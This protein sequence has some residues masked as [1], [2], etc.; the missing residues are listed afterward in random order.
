MAK[1]KFRTASEIKVGTI[2]YGASF[3]I[4]RH[5]LRQMQQAGM[6]PVAVADIDPDRLPEAAA[7]FPGIAT[8]N[9]ATELLASCDVDLLAICTPHNSHAPLAIECMN[10]GRHVVT[11]KP[12]AVNTEECDAMIAAR[13]RNRVMLSTYH[14]RHWDSWIINA[15]EKISGGM[16]GDVIRAQIDLCGYRCPKDTWRSSKTISGGIMYDWGAHCLEYAL[17]ILSGR[18]T[19][20]SG[21]A[22]RGFWAPRTCWGDDCIEDDTLAV[23]RFDSGQW[24]TMLNSNVDS[25]PRPPYMV[26]TGTRGVF[27][28]LYKTWKATCQETDPISG[29]TCTVLR[30]GPLPPDQ[31]HKFYEN[32]AAHLTKGEPLV[33]TPE[34]ARIPIRIM[35]LA[36]QSARLGKALPF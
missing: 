12:F 17:Q 33:I 31:T 11:E 14:N 27:H 4:A 7:D 5:H 3:R 6:T 28:V 20:V 8:Y 25:E 29:E 36:G 16:I 15:R 34:Y 23:V 26:V 22:H 10:A 30:S 1:K 32:I 19:E 9:S 18:V 13:D 2:G 21:F 35:D 24:L